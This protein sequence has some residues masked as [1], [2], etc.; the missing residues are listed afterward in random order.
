MVPGTNSVDMDYCFPRTV[1]YPITSI[2]QET[3]GIAYSSTS[4]DKLTGALIL[5]PIATGSSLF[6]LL[7]SRKTLTI[8]GCAG[9]TFF[10]FLVAA[11]S[12]R[13]GFLFSAL[14]ASIA[15]LIVLVTLIIDFVIFGAIKSHVNSSGT[16]GVSAAYGVAVWLTVAA[17]VSLFF[18]TLTT[19]FSCVTNRRRSRGEKY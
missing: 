8:K 2:I 7:S 19:C 17:F 3:T 6:L 10:A 4:L 1:G 18:G 5:H 16:A 11:L 14:I 15:W 13:L 9:V 12:N